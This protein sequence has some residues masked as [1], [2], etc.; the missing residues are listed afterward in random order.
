[1]SEVMWRGLTRCRRF[2]GARRCS[3][4]RG[5]SHARRRSGLVVRKRAVD[6][7]GQPALVELGGFRFQVLRADDRSP[8]GEAFETMWPAARS[9][10]TCRCARRCC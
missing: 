7:N 8:V 3:T 6:A 2:L 1:M 9:R 10:P 5:A 4:R